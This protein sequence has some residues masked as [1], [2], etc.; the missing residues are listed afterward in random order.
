MIGNIHSILLVLLLPVVALFFTGNTAQA[1]PNGVIYPQLIE[2]FTTADVAVAGEFQRYELDG[3]RRIE[4]QLSAGLPADP[5]ESKRIV[6][7]RLQ[8]LDAPTRA[9]MQRAAMGLVKALQYG[10]DRT[11]AIVF[12]AQVAIYGVTDLHAALHHYQQWREGSRQ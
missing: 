8:Q 10:V 3:I 11:P 5:G 7:Q 9:G 1:A 12:D 4:V 6:L 2:V